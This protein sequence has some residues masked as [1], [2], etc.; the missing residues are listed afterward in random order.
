M[1]VQR[2]PFP[3]AQLLYKGLA[4]TETEQGRPT[5]DLIQACCRQSIRRLRM[6]TKGL[7]G[8]VQGAT[9]GLK[10]W[11]ETWESW[12]EYN[13]RDQTPLLLHVPKEKCHRECVPCNTSATMKQ[14]RLSDPIDASKAGDGRI[15]TRWGGPHRC[16]LYHPT[17][18]QCSQSMA[19][20]TRLRPRPLL[21]VAQHQEWS[22][23]TQGP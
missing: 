8:S 23:M 3:A 6:G 18:A 5:A 7:A 12:H 21:Q 17:P 19:P 2:T 9:I 16:H 11:G 1:P 22:S 13:T 14:G 15:V 4:Q 20:A 10:V